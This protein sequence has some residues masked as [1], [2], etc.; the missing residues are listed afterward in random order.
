MRTA[1]RP[2]SR[3]PIGWDEAERI[4][5]ASGGVLSLGDKVTL[6]S[7]LEAQV[8]RF[9]AVLKALAVFPASFTARH[10]LEIV[11]ASEVDLVRFRDLHIIHVEGEGRFV[12]RE[13]VRQ[14]LWRKLT[15]EQRRRLTERYAIWFR[16]WFLKATPTIH[17]PRVMA[18]FVEEARGEIPHLKATVEWVSSQD[19]TI[20]GAIFFYNIWYRLNEMKEIL[21]E[22]V[23]YIE[24][25]LEKFEYNQNY[26][27][28]LCVRISI[29]GYMKED[30]YVNKL[31]E[32]FDIK[33]KFS[34]IY[35]AFVKGLTF[36]HF[37]GHTEEFDRL[38]YLYSEAQQS[39]P[40]DLLT[41]ADMTY[42]VAENWMSRQRFSEALPMN[43]SVLSFY[44]EVG[45]DAMLGAAL[46]Q[47]GCI[48]KGLER[49]EEA[50]ACWNEALEKFEA[51][52]DKHGEA[53]CLQ[54]IAMLHQESGALAEARRSVLQAI[55]LY[56]ECGDEAAVFAA[57]GTLGDILLEMGKTERA[58]TLYEEG[59]AFWKA[60]NHPRWTEKFEE[61]LRK[62][63]RLSGKMPA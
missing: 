50:R 43:E 45:S 57:G 48:L 42:I 8:G 1:P 22:N 29:H 26:I 41:S 31:Y 34:N 61:R 32:V 56:R 20:E 33:N 5:E 18:T 28:L 15:G 49:T 12:L 3:E 59:L 52:G 2:R 17:P 53:D 44:R 35:V 10:A 58:Q 47:R 37:R 63:D 6:E 38:Y 54:A 51:A 4:V 62:L 24:K 9:P 60:R 27:N 55:E 30:N 46:F 39:H 25:A 13:P 11:G 40:D 7:L 16:D 23:L 14:I 21:Q 19:V 36:C